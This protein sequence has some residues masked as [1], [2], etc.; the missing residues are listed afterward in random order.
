MAILESAN[1]AIDTIDE[2][3][4]LHEKNISL[5][6]NVGCSSKT[7]RKMFNYLERNSIIDIKKTA[8]TLGMSFNTVSGVVNKLCDMGIIKQTNSRRRNRIFAYEA[9]LD[10]LRSST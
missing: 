5:M 4:L 9:Y 2:L 10:I 7:V 8:S 6:M 1:N 3:V